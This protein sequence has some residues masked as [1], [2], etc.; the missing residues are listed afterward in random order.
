MM[1]KEFNFDDMRSFTDEEMNDVIQ[2]VIKNPEIKSILAF[3]YP[4]ADPDTLINKLKQIRKVQDFQHQFIASLILSIQKKNNSPIH[5]NGLEA[6][7]KEIKYLFISN[8]RDIIMDAGILNSMLD[9]NGWDTSEIA[10]GDNLCAKPWIS[11]CLRMNKC[12]LVKRSGTKRELFDAFIKLSAYIRRNITEMRNSVWIAQREG[13]TKDS[14]D[15]TQESLLKMLS[16]SSVGSLKQGFVDLNIS[17][18]CISY[19]YDSCDYLKAKEFQQKRDDEN[20]QKTQSDDILNM[21]VGI[22]GNKGKIYYELTPP[23][24]DEIEELIDEEDNRPTVLNKIAAIIDHRIHKNYHIFPIN[25]VALDLLN[26]TEENKNVHYT[27]K[28]KNDFEHYV[29][30]QIDKID[31][32]NKDIPFLKEKIWLMYANPLI[33]YMEANKQ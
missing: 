22:F 28:E 18:I 33:N 26:Q 8:H 31:L 3:A 4:D 2:R 20:F 19:E 24:N 6:L 13:R 9:F 1:E 30:R 23:I 5:F 12:F 11:D 29:E 15:R 17:P 16:V 25:Y 7:S 21:K 10:I 32:P 14:N 27:E